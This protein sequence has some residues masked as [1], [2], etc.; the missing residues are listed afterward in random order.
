MKKHKIVRVSG[1]RTV[2]PI[3]K[4][5]NRP[6]LPPKQVFGRKTDYNRQAAKQELRRNLASL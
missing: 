3:R 4:D 1:V 2:V 5:H 6:L